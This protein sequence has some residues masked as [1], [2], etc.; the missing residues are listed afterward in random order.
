MKYPKWIKVYQKL[1]GNRVENPPESLQ[2]QLISIQEKV[3]IE[4]GQRIAVTVGSRSISNLVDITKTV[5]DFLKS[6]G[7]HPFLVPAMG[8]HGGATGRGQKKI[9][10]E[11]CFTEESMDVPI[12]SSM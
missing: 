1:D 10:E 8:S 7:A 2:K 9:L 11:Y 3:S 5:I 12:L 4:K 6:K